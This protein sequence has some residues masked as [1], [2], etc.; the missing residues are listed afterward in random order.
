M[1]KRVQIAGSSTETEDNL[2]G[3]IRELRVDTDA[4]NLRLHDGVTPGGVTILNSDE[5]DSAIADRIARGDAQIHRFTSIV[6]LQARLPASDLI[7]VVEETNT[8]YI[9]FAGAAPIGT[10][11]SNISGYWLPIYTY[12]SKEQTTT[13]NIQ[14]I[15]V[16]IIWYKGAEI[17]GS[18]DAIWKVETVGT[19]NPSSGNLLEG[20]QIAT[21]VDL[22]LASTSAEYAM[23]S[24]SFKNT[25]APNTVVYTGW[26]MVTPWP[27]GFINGFGISNN[28]TDITNDL[29]F[30]SGI[31]RDVSDQVNIIQT[32]A[33]LIKRC[34]ALFVAGTNQGCRI[35][36]SVAMPAGPATLYFFVMYNPDTGACDFGGSLNGLYIDILPAAY[37]H[38]RFI[39]ALVVT[40]AALSLF[41]QSGD[42]FSLKSPSPD[43]N[44]VNPGAAAV[45][46]ALP[47]V[48]TGL[49]LEIDLSAYLKSTTVATSYYALISSLDLTD[50]LPATAPN[51]LL[52]T[53]PAAGTYESAV[54]LKIR[55]LVGNQVRTRLSVSDANLTFAIDV[56]GWKVDR[57]SL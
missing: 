49:N 46:R 53:G 10:I 9:W 27:K 22:P 42:T 40:G 8:V 32:T 44:V 47:S 3:L 7:A 36:G 17:N 11:A 35:D 34:D 38:R 6:Q 48:P 20:I 16:G 54:E 55:T 29:N 41:S 18:I 1:T 51:A 12:W 50:A 5:I 21:K 30:S 25:G 2:T 33:T 56:F 57:S 26:R 39:G 45:T 24:R 52:R 31:C 23:Y 13:L 28:V 43:V 19:N 37:T 14:A 4:R 15:K